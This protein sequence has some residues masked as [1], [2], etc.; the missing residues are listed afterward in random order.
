MRFCFCVKTLV[1]DK[2]NQ[3]LSAKPSLLL[4]AS[5]PLTGLIKVRFCFCVKTLVT[6][7]VNQTLSAKPSLLLLASK[8]LTGLIKVRFCFDEGFRGR[9]INKT[10]RQN[11][12]KLKKEK[13]LHPKKFSG[14]FFYSRKPILRFK[15]T[16]YAIKKYKKCCKRSKNET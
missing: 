8:P 15:E 2:V 7:K 5:K 4:L 3:T 9:K 1:T 16:S 10:F 6:D 11:K 12:P 14:V 13:D